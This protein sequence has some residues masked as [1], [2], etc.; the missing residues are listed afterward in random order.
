MSIA[1]CLI[2]NNTSPCLLHF[3]GPIFS[4]NF[5]SS[6]S[7][8][9]QSSFSPYQIDQLELP[10][11]ALVIFFTFC[12]SYHFAYGL[13]VPTKV[14]LFNPSNQ[15]TPNRSINSVI[16]CTSLLNYCET[17]QDNTISVF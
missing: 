3:P 13:L 9:D 2:P 15:L 4:F 10:I 12:F 14:N 1:F 11:N 17:K 5:L 16:K 7:Q 6:N 8:S